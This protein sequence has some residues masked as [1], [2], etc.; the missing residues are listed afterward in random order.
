MSG[1]PA[2]GVPALG[3]NQVG[4]ASNWLTLIL[5]A[6]TIGTIIWGLWRWFKIRQLA[7]DSGKQTAEERGREMDSRA[8]ALD[9]RESLLD[10]KER[11][12]SRARRGY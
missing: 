8:A 11:N 1:E 2:E 5:G 10:I 7:K 12:L 3:S 4:E 6:Y 9:I